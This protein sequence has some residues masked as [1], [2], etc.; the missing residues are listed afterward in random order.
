MMKTQKYARIEDNIVVELIETDSDISKLYHPD[1]VKAFVQCGDAVKQGFIY[2][3]NGFSEPVV[4]PIE[5]LSNMTI[6]A[7]QARLNLAA[8]GKLQTVLD[9]MSALQDTEPLKIV[10][11]Y[12]TELHRNDARLVDFCQDVLNLTSN[13]IDALFIVQ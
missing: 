3:G 11:E 8:I 6:S 1:I 7:A 9:Y 12:A 2:D 10:W 13:E 4:T 5:S